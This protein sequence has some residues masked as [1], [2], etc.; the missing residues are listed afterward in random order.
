[1]KTKWCILMLL[2]AAAFARAQT[3]LTAL[4]QQ[5]LFEEQ[6]NR[7]LDAAISNYQSLATQFDKDR[8]LAATAIFRL[9]ECYRMQGKTNEAARE[10]QR[11]VNEFPNQSTLVTL[12]HQN[13]AAIGAPQSAAT[14]PDI[15]EAKLWNRVK[16]LPQNQLE[17]VLPT[18]APDLLLTSLLQ[19]RDAAETKLAELQNF[20][21]PQTP[22]VKSQKSVLAAINEQ[23]SEKINGIMEALKLRAE[24]AQTTAPTGGPT[25]AQ[26]QEV[27]I[28]GFQQM[29]QNSPDLINAPVG[30][31]TPLVKAVSDGLLKVAE[32]LLD[33]GAGVNVSCPRIPGLL[34]P[35]GDVTPLM[36]AVVAGN[37]AMTQFLID[38]GADVNAKTQNGSTPLAIAAGKGFQAVTEVLLANKADVNAR[39]S[40][41]QTPLMF[42]ASAGHLEVVKLLL[43]D[44]ANVNLKD[45]LGRTALNCAIGNPPE[46]MQAL[47]HAGADP[48]TEDNQGRTPLSYASERDNSE[49][50][51]VLLD[52]KANPNGGKPL[53]APLLCAVHEK[54][55]VSAELLLQAGANPNVVGGVSSRSTDHQTTY[56]RNNQWH[57]TP[58]WLAIYLDD[59]AMVQLLLKYKADPN[60]SQTDGKPVLFDALDRTNILE[61]LLDSGG[62]ANSRMS[63]GWPLLEQA[64]SNGK[65]PMVQ[66]LLQHGADSN[67]RDEAQ[68]SSA[69][70][71]TPLHFA[72]EQLADPKIFEL[73]LDHHADPNVRGNDGK[74][75]LDLLKEKMKS[76][77]TAN[78]NGF[79]V[80]MRT[81][82]VSPKEQQTETIAAQ[83]ADLLRQHG[84]LDNLPDWDAI[85]VSRPSKKYSAV[86][87][88]KSTNDWN[89]FTLLELI[90]VQYQFLAASP[91]GQERVRDRSD[92]LAVNGQRS[93]ALSFPDLANIRIR[94][95]SPDGRRWRDL[96]VDLKSILQSGE[97]SNNV[98]LK[99]GDVVEIPETDHPFSEA[100]GGFS[101][102]QL[103]NLM[104][105]LTRRVR[106]TVKGQST[107]ITLKP[108][109][110]FSGGYPYVVTHAPFW[111]EPVLRNSNLLLASSDLSHITVI[112]RD[113]ETG[114]KK[115]WTMDCSN[116]NFNSPPAFWLRNGDVIIVP[117]K[118]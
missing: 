37:K 17:Q 58:L 100:W 107:A 64:V 65:V 105:C 69:D 27:Q 3:N 104:R 63:D 12:S 94:R 93:S 70:G 28:A 9:G 106:I 57:L 18:L 6:A 11:I 67:V 89:R 84:A 66:L 62:D 102:L 116:P 88:K 15:P 2:L 44:G 80:A 79:G 60:D 16:D 86:V 72:A 51:K 115:E 99:W 34:D 81:I 56:F 78:A 13:L 82:Y 7:N 101:P 75:P 108:D 73:L 111:I 20:Y 90:A 19:Q 77:S 10:Y 113:P 41:G 83:L 47:L 36:A 53:N 87:F 97:C 26:A 54:N 25:L 38:R 32:Y 59:S 42:A 40:N 50:V 85:E 14:P 22:D 5:G 117:E 112:R 39:D 98:P 30:G 46:I 23:I 45:T 91:A 110:E 24:L 33:H 4:L 74:T 68:N 61:V 21:S 29:I 43:A 118:E 8:Q 1:M 48:N 52:A 35:R 109:F 76:P 49:V 103:T 55:I 96:P 71:Y 114:K 31:S 95:P 92:I